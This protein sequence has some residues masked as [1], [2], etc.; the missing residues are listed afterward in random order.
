MR[1][2]ALTSQCNNGISLAYDKIQNID[3]DQRYTKTNP[4]N[5]LNEGETADKIAELKKKVREQARKIR[6]SKFVEKETKGRSPK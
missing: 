2:E 1:T 5:P 6:N 4:E 3:S